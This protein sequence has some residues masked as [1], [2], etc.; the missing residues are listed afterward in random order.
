MRNDKLRGVFE[1]LDFSNVRTVI[2][3]GNVL[4]E[5]DS[6]AV[7]ALE[8]KVEEALPKRLGFASTAIDPFQDGDPGSRGPR[9]V[10]GHR[11][12]GNEQPERDLSQEEAAHGTHLSLPHPGPGL[13]D[14]GDVWPGHLQRHRPDQRQDAGS[15]AMDGE[16]VWERDD[17]ENVQDRRADPQEAERIRLRVGIGL[18]S[19]GP[20]AQE[21]LRPQDVRVA[22]IERQDGRAIGALSYGS[23]PLDP[24][25]LHRSASEI[26]WGRSRTSKRVR[27]VTEVTDATCRSWSAPNSDPADRASAGLGYPRRM[28]QMAARMTRL[29]AVAVFKAAKAAQQQGQARPIPARSRIR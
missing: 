15:H 29:L 26:Q 3:S 20:A 12:L 21:Q 25:L 17:D 11:S 7:R 22:G 5:T 4:F 9:P 23:L 14:P 10:R 19:D 6:S 24:D 1:D 8:T 16:G 2:T 27:P 18:V 28:V 13:H